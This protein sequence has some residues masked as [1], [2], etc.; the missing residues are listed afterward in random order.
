MI[1]VGEVRVGLIL[2]KRAAFG[3]QEKFRSTLSVVNR[4]LT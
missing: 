4:W 2:Q 3:M 1:V